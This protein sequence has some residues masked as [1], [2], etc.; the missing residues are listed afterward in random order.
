MSDERAAPAQC[1]GV[2]VGVG[3]G[4]TV[5]VPVPPGDG[6]TDGVTEGVG[7]TEPVGDGMAVVVAVGDTTSAVKN[8]GDVRLQVVP[9]GAVKF[10]WTST[11]WLIALAWIAIVKTASPS[12]VVV[13]FSVSVLP[14]GQ[15]TVAIADAPL[16]PTGLPE[17]VCVNLP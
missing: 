3:D 6:D 9:F 17:T 13:V 12:L 10:I 1:P 4:V 14:S 2:F 11:T 15:K 7:E 5:G 16:T 8:A